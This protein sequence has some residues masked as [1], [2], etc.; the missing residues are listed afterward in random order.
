MMEKV[1]QILLLIRDLP[2]IMFGL[3]LKM[4]KEIFGSA[5]RKD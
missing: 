3:L 2:T 1:L 4:K 5:R